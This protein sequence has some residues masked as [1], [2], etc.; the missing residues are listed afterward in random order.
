MFSRQGSCQQICVLIMHIT[1]KS[2]VLRRNK[3]MAIEGGTVSDYYI[4]VIRKFIDFML[5]FRH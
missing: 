3:H 4:L 1:S 5:L 2:M